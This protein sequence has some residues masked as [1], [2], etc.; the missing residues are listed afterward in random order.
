MT[1]FHSFLFCPS[2]AFAPINSH[3]SVTGARNDAGA[4]EA[5]CGR[6]D[7]VIRNS[8]VSAG[9]APPRSVTL[10]SPLRP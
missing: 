8:Q 7:R 10:I 5:I 2:P 4:W 6:P 3:G 9:A 1:Q